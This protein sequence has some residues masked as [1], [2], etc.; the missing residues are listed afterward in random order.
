MSV[1]PLPIRSDLSGMT[2]DESVGSSLFDAWMKEPM[3][4][5]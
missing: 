4:G 1:R 3:L 5:M 2:R